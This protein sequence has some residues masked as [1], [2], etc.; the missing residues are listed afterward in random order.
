CVCGSDL[1]PY[2]GENP[3]NGP[4][5]TGHELVGVVEQV[6]SAVSTV[7]P[8]DFVI[9][10]FVYADN[11]CA[12]C[13]LGIQTGCPHGG[14]WGTPDSDGH[15]VDGLQGELVR[16]PFADGTLVKTPTMPD[17]SLIP[18]LLA[19]ADVFPTG[20]HAATCAGVT[21]G[22]TVVVVGDGAVGLCAVLAAKRLGADRVIAMSRHPERQEL[23]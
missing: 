11:T 17:D 15:F 6:G 5:R 4:T 3:F 13:Q 7:R 2:R 18:H 10:P 14:Y 19:L 9:V 1:W 23:A 20:H 22:S 8:G 21:T 16:V 12:V